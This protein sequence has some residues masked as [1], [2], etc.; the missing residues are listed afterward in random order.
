MYAV[1]GWL[2]VGFIAV[3]TAPYWLRFIN[4]HTLHLKGGLYAKTIKVLRTVHKPLGAAVLLI[5]LI[6][7]YLALGALRLHTGTITGVLLLLTA[8]LGSVFFFTKKK[9]AFV[10]HKRMV[11]LLVIF[12]AIHLLF[13]SAVYYLLN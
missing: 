13:P 10:W 6:H 11:G 7:G 5:M 9:A 1:L 2:N 8:M 3:M 4:N 12:I